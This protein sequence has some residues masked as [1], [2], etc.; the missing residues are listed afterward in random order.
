MKIF[1]NYRR[2]TSK[3][4]AGR[5]FDV[6]AP[7]FG[8]ANVF[9]DVDSNP[10][11]V[12]FVAH[13]DAKVAECDV[14]LALIE[15]N[16]LSVSGQN[17][18]RKL[19]SPG[20]FVR[21]EI[22]GALKRAKPIPVIPVLVDDARMPLAEELPESLRD[23]VHRHAVSVHHAQFATDVERLIRK[24]RAIKQTRPMR[25]FVYLIW[26]A[27][28]IA[29]AGMAVAVRSSYQQAE[30]QAVK[31]EFA[32]QEATKQEAAKQE[33]AKQ[34][35]AKQEAAK[36][37]A[38]KQQVPAANPALQPMQSAGI[39][40]AWEAEPTW[41]GCRLQSQI[42]SLNIVNGIVSADGPR[43]RNLSGGANAQGKIKF[44]YD[45]RDETGT[46]WTNFFE[47]SISGNRGA[48]RAWSRYC[49]GTFV[50]KRK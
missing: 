31:E 12:N 39:D 10:V 14:F 24:I 22:E 26:A 46:E 44:Q 37:E 11:G 29:A 17:G 28:I 50:M 45:I 20:D 2:D 4:T 7:A 8:R 3:G 1:I 13:L 32:K 48:G 25:Y 19:D 41:V 9:M 49:A 15:S 40:G 42:V 16:W 6:L 18:Q 47:G 34:E 5:L 21:I 43:P 23:L 27:L 33:G 35:A 38:A 36:Q 30:V